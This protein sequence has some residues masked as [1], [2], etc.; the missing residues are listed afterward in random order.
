[1]KHKRAVGCGMWDVGGG[2][3]EAEVTEKQG[4]EAEKE[5]EEKRREEKELLQ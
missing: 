5:K 1:M 2:L 3:W 4:T